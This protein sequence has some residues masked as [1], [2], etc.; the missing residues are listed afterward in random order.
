MSTTTGPHYLVFSESTYAR[1]VGRWRFRFQR[2]DGGETFEA[3]DIEP[4]LG[5]ERLAL[6]TVVRALEA[7]DQPSQVTLV[8]TDP[9]VQRGIRYGLPQ[10]RESGWRWEC[11]GQMVPVKDADLWQ[12]LER[13][14]EFHQVDC[15]RWRVDPAHGSGPAQPGPR[16]NGQRAA[17]RR[18]PEGVSRLRAAASGLFRRMTASLGRFPAVAAVARTVW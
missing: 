13:A 18:Q 17:A 11:F 12:R 9:Y 2:D 6:L 7:L 3:A 4:K 16:R 5:G 1:G 10:W 15:R 8:N 14:L